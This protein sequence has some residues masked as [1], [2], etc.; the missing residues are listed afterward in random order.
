MNKKTKILFTGGGSGGP[1]APHL[2]VVD[3]LR[4]DVNDYEFLWLGTD[5]GLEKWM[6][7]GA[8]IKCQT[9]QS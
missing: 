2:A 9:K 8:D 1:V 3:T 4:E 5:K 6:V 7:A